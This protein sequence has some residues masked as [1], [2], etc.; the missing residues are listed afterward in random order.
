MNIRPARVRGV[1]ALLVIS[2]LLAG[3]HSALPGYAA[4]V[5]F[6]RIQV[7]R[8]GHALAVLEDGSVLLTG[9]RTRAGAVAK[10]E[11]L[12]ALEVEVA[13]G[14]TLTVARAEHTA[15]PLLDGRVLVVGGE[16]GALIDSTE[17]YDPASKTFAFGPKLKI[18]RAGHSATLLENGDVLIAGGD[19]AGTAE[20]YEASS[21][22]FRLL[23]APMS[24]SRKNHSTVTL[25]DGRVLHVGGLDNQ[26]KALKT[27]EVFDPATGIFSRVG[28]LRAERVSPRL[29]L[30]PDGKVQVI[31][32]NGNNNTTLEMYN[33]SGYFTAEVRLPRSLVKGNSVSAN[34]VAETVRQRGVSRTT[35]GTVTIRAEGEEAW[36]TTDLTDYPPGTTVVITGGGFL[37]GETINLTIIRSPETEEE[38][39]MTFTS[40]ADELGNF[41]NTDFATIRDDIDAS[42]LLTATGAQSGKTAYT[43]F[44]DSPKVGSATVG[45][46]VGTLTSGT[47]GSATYQITVN[48]GSGGGSSGAFTASF[49][50]SGLPAGVTSSFSPDPVSFTPTQNSRTATLTLTT[51]AAT[52]SGVTPFTVKAATSTD[53]F[54]VANGTLTIDGAPNAAPVLAPIGNKNVNELATLSFTAT[55]TDTD[56]SQALTFS[57]IDAPAGASIDPSTGAFSWTPSES[58]GGNVFTFT[59]KVADNGSPV[60]SDEEQ[61]QVTVAEVNQAPVLA[62]IG[63]RSVDEFA[64]L[65]FSASASDDDLPANTLSYSLVGA[66]GGA[67]INS[68][69]GAFSW[70]PGEADGGSTFTFTVKV[71]DNGSPAHSDEEEI[72]VTVGEVNAAPTLGEIGDRSVDELVTLSFTATAADSDVPTNDLSFALINGPAGA[73]IDPAS[74]A[75]SW[76]PT[77][78]QGGNIFTFKVSVTDNGSPNLS[79]E[80]EISVTVNEVNQAPVLAAIGNKSASEFSELTFTAS[81]TDND[82]PA[83]GLTYSLLGAPAGATIDATSGAFSWT[84]GEADGGNTFTFT[85]KVT[86]DGTPALSHEEQIQVTVAEVNAAPVLGAIGNQTVDELANLSFTATATDSDVPANTFAFSLVNA[87]AGASI[88]PSSGAFSWTPT[89]AQGPGTF[90]FTVVVTDNGSPAES[91]EQQVQV[92]VNEV[93]QAPALAAIGNRSASEFSELTFTA[94][95]TDNDLPANGLTYS[96][97]GAPAGATIDATTGAF[98]WTPGEA[99]GGNTFTF[100]VKVTDDGTPALSHEEQIQVTV[101]EVNAAPVLGAIGNQTVDELANLSFTATATD[102]DVPANTFAFSLVNAPAG[103]SIDP[104]S[105]AFSWTPTEAQGPGTFTF[106]VVVTDNGSPA[107]SDEQQ[108]QVTVN[109]VNQAPALAAI[110]NRS[111]SEFSELTFTASATDNDLPANGLT[112]SLLGA[113]AGATIDATTGA[114]SWTPGEADGGN[115]FTFTVKVTDDGTPALSHEEQ[116]QV[117][118]A[119]VNAAPVLGA[120]GNQTVDELANLS[121]TATATDSDVPANT[122][123]FSL[124]NAP[125]GASIDPASGAFSWTPTEAQGPGTFTFT[126]VVTDNG[127]PAESDEQQVQVTVNE[128]NQAPVLAAI[129]SKSASEFSELTFTASGTDSDLPANGLTYSLLGAPAGATIDA[130]SGAFSWTPGEADGGNTFTFTVKVTDDGTPALSHQ[131]QIQVTVAEANAAP[132]LGLIGNRTVDELANLSFTATASDSD[133]PA[134]SFTFSLESGPA[135]ASINPATGAFSWTPT[136]AQG[137]GTYTFTVRVTDDGSPAESDTEAI[138]VTVNEVNIAPQLA[139]ITDK[140]VDEGSLLSV[141]AVGSDADLPEQNL[142]YS[143]TVSPAGASINGST[144]EFTWTPSELQGPGDY[145]VTVQVS[146]GLAAVTTSFSIHV[147]EVNAAPVLGSIGNKT[148]DELANLS[149]TATATDSDLPANSV[150][151]SLVGAPQGAS[152][153]P[154]S[155]AFSWTPTEAQGPGTFTFTVKATDDGA[156][157]ESDEETIQ[158]T[159]GEVN[160]APEL[161]AIGNQTVD[162]LALLSVTAAGSDVDL[163]AQTLVYSLTAAPSGASIDP[164]TGQ[165]SWTPSEVQGPGNYPVTVQVSDGTAAVTTSFN[166]QV[167]EVNVA[168]VLASI[169]NKSSVWGSVLSFTASASDADLPANALTFSLDPGAPAGASIDPASGAFTWTPAAA[170]VGSHAITIRVTDNGSP[171]ANDSETITVEVGRR[172]TALVYSG[173]P[174]A[175]YSDPAALRA[176]LTDVL[177]AAGIPSKTISFTIGTQSGSG[178]TN[179]SGLA[180]SS[181]TLNQAPAVSTVQSSFAGDAAY[182]PASDSDQF[183]ITREDAAVIFTGSNFVQTI[184]P[185]SG[186]ATV[187]LSATIQDITAAG[188]DSYPGDIRNAKVTFVNRDAANAPISPACKDLTV[189]LV[190]PGDLK[191]GTVVCNWGLSISGDS[192]D[193]TVGIVVNNYYTRDHGTDNEVITVS[194]PLTT[195]FI[196]GGGY[197]T[198]QRA[199]GTNAGDVGSKNNFGFNVKYNKSG[200]NLQGSINTIIRKGGRV[201]QVKGNSMTSLTA[202]KSVSTALKATFNGKA[203][204][205]DVTNPLAPIALGGNATL[206]VVMTDRGEP[207]RTDSIAITVWESS[208]SLFF[209]SSW[210]GTKTAEQELQGGNLVVR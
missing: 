8:P 14:P 46:Q 164:G 198:L 20:L 154:V 86:D 149:F 150:S 61:I 125:A 199:A 189:S 143:L 54:A 16:N 166:V 85:V 155:G 91:D 202:N 203:S 99:D 165:F 3:V 185:S 138:Q 161:A 21:D 92:T 193:Y 44:T 10:S 192:A 73:S 151:F 18:A 182:L 208:G 175:Q 122:F 136:E 49:T 58:Q 75:F 109:E 26:G 106:T 87:P 168:P 201:Y 79:D 200:K 191:T 108:V 118:V 81:A 145:P 101:A 78:S 170:Q 62:A 190:N 180:T 76:T 171:I 204:I 37:P 111:A 167:N 186:N 107:E 59:V 1:L 95:A 127:S 38:R 133:L 2:S 124:V 110:G 17:I 179:G 28:D 115:T 126:V 121:F 70:T 172:A 187:T 144:G 40:V 128:V 33:V 97:L 84:P 134:N 174:S 27:A 48:R 160:V 69:T 35:A 117:T 72:D 30:L 183:T 34:S 141:T 5:Q 77:E 120:I 88:D 67:S 6:E 195:D 188:G 176:T 36:V 80:E 15:T 173:D 129:G 32:G 194:R 56:A 146:D 31:G 114:F 63:D 43:S 50:I 157:A 94:S 162:E 139:S 159:V 105:G 55:A 42:F 131:E 153:D 90:T 82:A 4:S 65:S 60:Q 89:E 23:A 140:T 205:Q 83:N 98:S 41:T 24:S 51:V 53:D 177:A 96:L 103:A 74:G 152:I 68:S 102:S 148:V 196:T 71:T 135:G 147:N 156:P 52:P 45:A 25:K 184:S 137:P 113:P 64:A 47:A 7:E 116:I 93:N 22:S 100:T 158:V 142:V 66:P 123:A 39:Q 112:Y 210:D 12:D 19:A 169:G 209:A 206:Q 197:L 119:E 178:T 29:R 163:P 9:G 207:G 130:T 13:D 132:V 104:A 57:L 181:I 11:V